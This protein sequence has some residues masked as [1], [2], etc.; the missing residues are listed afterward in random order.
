MTKLLTAE[1]VY[2]CFKT[3]NVPEVELNNALQLML[4]YGVWDLV[5]K[6]GHERF[7]F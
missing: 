4:W 5:V 2:G 3:G 1:E 6:E 7:I